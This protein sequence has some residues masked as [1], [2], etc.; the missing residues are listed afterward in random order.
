VKS[1]TDKFAGI[2]ARLRDIKKC[3]VNSGGETPTKNPLISQGKK[4]E[5]KIKVDCMHIY[6]VI[7]RDGYRNASIQEHGSHV[8]SDTK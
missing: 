2:V 3:I 4:L 6:D 1:R 7:I 5:E 8:N